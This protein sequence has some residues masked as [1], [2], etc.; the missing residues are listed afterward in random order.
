[1]L[2]L[3]ICWHAS[4]IYKVPDLGCFALHGRRGVSMLKGVCLW[5]RRRL[6]LPRAKLLSKREHYNVG[7]SER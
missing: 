1:M 6:L 2:C 5:F 3:E 4:S 7:T